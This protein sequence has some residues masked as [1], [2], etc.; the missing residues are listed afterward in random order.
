MLIIHVLK[1]KLRA[2]REAQG[3]KNCEPKVLG[4][5]MDSTAAMA[6]PYLVGVLLPGV[7]KKNFLAK[8]MLPWMEQNGQ[9]QTK[10]MEIAITV[11]CDEC[12]VVT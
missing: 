8:T 1:T 9:R 2:P 12:I 11:R 5:T 3:K 10:K 4:F 6:L 7:S